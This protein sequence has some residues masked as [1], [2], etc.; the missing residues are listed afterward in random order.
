MT[1]GD[2]QESAPQQPGY[3]QPSPE[4]LAR[5]ERGL[6]RFLDRFPPLSSGESA[7]EG[8]SDA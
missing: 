7:T 2:A 6:L 3:G 1:V 8:P 5:S 4:L